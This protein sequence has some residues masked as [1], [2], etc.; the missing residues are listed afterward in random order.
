[1]RA[2]LLSGPGVHGFVVVTMVVVMAVVVVMPLIVTMA[3]LVM[4]VLVAMTVR[5]IVMQQPRTHEID[6]QAEHGNR[7]RL[8][9]VDH[10]GV[11]EPDKRFPG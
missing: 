10:V 6:N 9:E 5:M 2:L 3:M 8:L 7:D 1:M 11:H 4:G